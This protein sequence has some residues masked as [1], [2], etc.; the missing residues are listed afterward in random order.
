VIED[1]LVERS[2]RL[3]RVQLD[4]GG[5]L[6]DWRAFDLVVAMGGPMGAYEDE[7]FPWLVGERALLGAAASAGTPCLGVCLGAQLLAA[8]IGGRAF[9]GPAPEVGVF[10]V[11]LTAAG[12]RDAVL[13]VLPRRFTVLQWHSDTFDLP[14]DAVVLASSAAY[15]RQAFR[16]RNAFGLQFHAE[17][18]PAMA[19]EWALVPESVSYL[20]TTLGPGAAA[21]LFDDLRR[22]N[23]VINESCRLLVERFLDVTIRRS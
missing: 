8:A 15:P 19:E 1:V 6:P 11:D 18:T 22:A 9:P 5:A 2:A 17:V 3:H 23:K 20:E 13:S 16:W 21:A 10:D 4:A 7:A 14:D 12:R